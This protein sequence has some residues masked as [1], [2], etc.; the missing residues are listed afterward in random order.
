M[1]TYD[2][3]RCAFGQIRNL[4]NPRY[5]NLSVV[6]SLTSMCTKCLEPRALHL[7]YALVSHWTPG[8]SAL[9]V[10]FR[11]HVVSVIHF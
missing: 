11:S 6:V 1:R 9:N 7:Y 8:S 3:T 4:P 5:N 2:Q 10:S